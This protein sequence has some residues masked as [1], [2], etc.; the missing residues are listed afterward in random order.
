M[1]NY[2][3]EN[4]KN[5]LKDLAELIFKKVTHNLIILRILSSFG[6]FIKQKKNYKKGYYTPNLKKR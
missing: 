5:E 6:L 2:F 4:T 3:L 1:G